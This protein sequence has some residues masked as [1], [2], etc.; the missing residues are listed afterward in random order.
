MPNDRIKRLVREPDSAG[1]Y[2]WTISDVPLERNRSWVAKGDT[3]AVREQ[4][5]AL[6]FTW[7]ARA[8]TWLYVGLQPPASLPDGISLAEITTVYQITPLRLLARFRID[9][10]GFG[11]GLT[12]HRLGDRAELEQLSE[13]GIGLVEI[14]S[15]WLAN[16]IEALRNH[17]NDSW[18]EIGGARFTLNDLEAAW[19]GRPLVSIHAPARGATHP[20]LSQDS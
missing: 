11:D 2:H 3:Y 5:K 20:D 9:E 13:P 7:H 15:V 18:L 10:D 16:S 1:G 14:E 12:L 6:G 8:R 19:N 17:T 4:L